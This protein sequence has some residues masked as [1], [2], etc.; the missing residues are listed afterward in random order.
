MATTTRAAD[1]R[2]GLKVWIAVGGPLCSLALVLMGWDYLHLK[3]Q[4]APHLFAQSPVVGAA[5]PTPIARLSPPWERIAVPAYPVGATVRR[6]SPFS[7]VSP[8]K[9]VHDASYEYV[10]DGSLE[11]ALLMRPRPASAK[12]GRHAQP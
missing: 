3:L 8:Y 10:P 1:I 11:D 6:V 4:D 5:V 12:R 7:Y 2:L 9:G